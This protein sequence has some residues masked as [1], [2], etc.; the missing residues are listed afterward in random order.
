[1]YHN[2]IYYISDIAKKNFRC[3]GT[4]GPLAAARRCIRRALLA[5]R[6]GPEA[7]HLEDRNM[8]SMYCIQAGQAIPGEKSEASIFVYNGPLTDAEKY[9]L[10]QEFPLDPLDLEAINDPE[11]VPRIEVSPDGLLIIWSRPDN[12]SSG[13]TVQFEVSTLGLF[14]GQGKAAAILPRGQLPMAAREFKHVGSA[15]DFVLRVLLCTVHEYQAHLKAIKAK[16]SELESKIASSMENKY[17]LQMLALGE[18][19]IYYHSGLEANSTIL[20]RLRRIAGK[21]NFSEEQTDFLDNVIIEYQQA[22]KQAKIYST[23]LS[24]LMDARGSIVNNNLNVL[25]KNL[26]LINVVF[27]PLN[28]IASMG[29]M[30]EFSMIIGSYN[31]DWRI[32]YL[33]FALGMATV[34]WITLTLTRKVINRNQRKRSGSC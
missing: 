21:L 14:L 31:I 23:V 24:G 19:L 16:S 10:L 4:C 9:Q 15:E 3:N 17:L 8:M 33:A 1:M 22:V 12:I 28:L 2:N 13:D 7:D 11:E 6:R 18:S 29:G 26:T 20:A 27:L 34:G 32:G 30:S 5:R 25:L